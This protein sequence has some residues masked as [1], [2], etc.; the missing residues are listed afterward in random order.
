MKISFTQ[1]HFI[2][3]IWLLLSCGALVA[4]GLLIGTQGK[5]LIPSGLG[6]SGILLLMT[7]QRLP[8]FRISNNSFETYLKTIGLGVAIYTAVGVALI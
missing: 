8:R 1:N 5:Y 7:R 3:T 2:A 6:V 4:T